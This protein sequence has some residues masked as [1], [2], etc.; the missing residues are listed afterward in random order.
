MFFYSYL[1][2]YYYYYYYYYYKH[3]TYTITTLNNT[4]S[5]DEM[6]LVDSVKYFKLTIYIK[7]N[8]KKVMGDNKRK[9][10]G[11]YNKF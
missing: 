4:Y 9:D 2:M 5:H 10:K 3:L 11:K 6:W 8:L 7:I 1:I